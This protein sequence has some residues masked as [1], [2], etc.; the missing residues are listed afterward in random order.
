MANPIVD[1]DGN[2]IM[3]GKSDVGILINGRLSYLSAKELA[4][5]LKGTASSDI[6]AIELITNPSAKYDAAGMAGMINIVMKTQNKVGFNATVNS[7]VGAGRK[8]RY[9]G[10]VNINYQKDKWNFTA[11]YN[12][13]YR[14]EEEYRY[15]GI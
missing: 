4:V 9:G 10:G 14:G 13:T 6:K 2:I 11:G 5:L 1:D 15:P 12:G 7:F 3:R 8:E